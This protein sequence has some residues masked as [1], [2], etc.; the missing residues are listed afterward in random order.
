MAAAASGDHAQKARTMK[1]SNKKLTLSHA[2]GALFIITT[3]TILSM[4]QPAIRDVNGRTALHMAVYYGLESKMRKLIATG[5]DV[6]ASDK[7]GNRPL[8]Y[9]VE[10]MWAAT[11][12]PMLLE[13]GADPNAINQNG[14]TP[15][16]NLINSYLLPQ[17]QAPII[18]ML[19]RAGCNVNAQDKS[20]ATVLH[21]AAWNCKP[22]E[23]AQIIIAAGADTT[24]RTIHEDTPLHLAL[25]SPH[26]ELAIQLIEH[27]TDIDA[28]NRRGER[29]I[30]LLTRMC[31]GQTETMQPLLTRRILE[32][33]CSMVE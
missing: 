15:L 21:H 5:I 32:L 13:A 6:N 31:G 30:F 20:G 1:T 25:K 28:C 17:E 9:A 22:L 2:L 14:Q 33:G 23:L 16:F 7:R 4:Q 19:T 27:G 3:P 26:T 18:T 10:S 8:N 24:I 11:M 29:P 12:V